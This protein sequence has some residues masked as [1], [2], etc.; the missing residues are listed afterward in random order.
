MLPMLPIILVVLLGLAV[1]RPCVALAEGER[2]VGPTP[3]R[4]ASIAGDASFWRPGADDWAPAQVNT[5]LAAGDDLYTGDRGNLEVEIG[6]RAFVRAGPGTEVGLE[7]LET[8]FLQFKVPSG[9]AAFDLQRVPEGQRIEVD[10]PNGAFTIDRAG[11]YRADVDDH[12]TTFASRRGGDATVIPAGGQ[13][14]DVPDGQRVVLQGTDTP[15]VNVSAAP[16][17]D[18]WDRWNDA[19][20]PAHPERPRSAEYVPPNVAGVDDLDHYGDWRDT[21]RYGH[22]WVPRGTP[23]DWAPYST[24]RWTWDPYYQ[25][26]WV[27]DAPWGWA[28]Y[29]YGRWVDLD[30]SWG[31]TPGPVVAPAVYAPALVGFVGPVGVSVNVGIGV[32]S[33][34][35]VALGFGEPVLP[36][37]GPVGFIGRPFWGGWHGPRVVNNVVINNTRIVNATTINRFQN[38]SVRNAVIGVRRD[39]FGHGRTQ[40][41]RLGPNDLQQLRPV[42]GQLGIK[43]AAAS[44]VAAPGHGSRP[45]D[46]VR[47]R[48]VVATRAPQDPARRLQAAGLPA[49]TPASRAPEPRIVQ[50]RQMARAG[51]GGGRRGF[52]SEPPPPPASPRERNATVGEQQHA[53]TGVPGGGEGQHADRAPAAPGSPAGGGSNRT[54]EAASAPEHHAQPGGHRAAPPP[55]ETHRAPTG[56]Y[57]GGSHDREASRPLRS[58]SSGRSAFAARPSRPA[59]GSAHSGHGPHRH[60]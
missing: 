19:R 32:P 1:L 25:W 47:N 23:S 24:G 20:A 40:L 31:W 58:P 60:G 16:A 21:P 45:P 9:Q 53:A 27:D 5:P 39:Q 48:A 2:A 52:G 12:G 13:A 36:W 56:R 10:T 51:A 29:H 18:A 46:A 50:P 6:P 43:P 35:W 34:G 33:V 22:V 44:L 38:M 41:A 55:R 3:P 7:S 28:P 49:A 57:H 11:Y 26:T 37:W 54:G 8:G 14:T 15:S 42:H 30:G 4:L 17:P 59:A